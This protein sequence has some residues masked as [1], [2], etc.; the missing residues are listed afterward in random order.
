MSKFSVKKPLTIFVAVVM[1][2]VLGVVSYTK[3]TPDLLPSIDMPYVVVVTPYPGASPQKVERAVTKPLEQSLATLDNIKNVQSMSGENFSMVFME[4]TNDVNM[5]TV[6]VDIL[7]YIDLI[8]PNWDEKV[9]SPYILKM[10]PS[11]VPVLVAAVSYE[12]KDAEEI[13]R[14]L[15]DTLLDELDGVTGIAKVNTSGLIETD[16]TISISQEKI[17][18][19]NNKLLGTVNGKLSD[20]QK[21]LL[22]GQKKLDEAKAQ[23]KEQEDKLN[24]AK[25]STYDQLAE[26]KA[27]LNAGIAQV[28]ALQT[29]IQILEGDKMALE[30]QIQMANAGMLPGVNVTNLQ[31]QLATV[32]S[33]LDGLKAACGDAQA[34]LEELKKAYA[35]AEKGSYEA[36][37]QFGTLSDQMK[38]GQKQLADSQKTLNDG[39]KQMRDSSK[40]ALEQ[41]N[42]SGFITMD[43]ISGILK[44][45]NFDM[46]A[47]YV[48]AGD[49][50]VLVSVGDELTSKKEIADLV[51]FNIDGLGDVRVKDVATVTLVN[52]ADQ[53]YGNING[54]NGVLLTFSKQSNFATTISTNNLE[55]KFRALEEKYDG[56]S[57]TTL[58]S[59]GQYIYIIVESILSSL[60]WGALFA[61]IILLLF[62]RNV[63]PTFIT[64]CSIPISL[65]FAI[66]LMYFSGVTINMMSLSGLAVSVGMLVDNSVVVIENIYR[67][68]RNGVPVAKAAVAGAKQVSMAITA[69]TLTTLCVFLPIVFTEGITRSLFQD[70]ALTI[71]FALFASLL[72]ALTLVPAMSS[73]LLSKP[74]KEEGH[75]FDKLIEKY[76]KAIAWGLD[77][78][79]TI[80]GTTLIA[81]VVSLGISVGKGFIFIPEMSMPMMSGQVVTDE[82]ATLEETVEV[83]N[84]VVDKI[85]EVEGV[86]SCGAMLASQNAL[87]LDMG[88]GTT[89]QVSL[90][91]LLED[92]TKRSNKEIADEINEKCKGV[93]ATVE[94]MTSSSVTEYTSALGGSGVSL[95]L[96]GD[97]ERDL[98]KAAK[99]VGEAIEKLEGVKKV[100]NGIEELDR[101]FHFT[102]DKKKAAQNGLTVAQIY[103]EIANKLNTETEATS[104]TWEAEDYSINVEKSDK[105][106]VT[107]DDILNM[108][109]EANKSDG[110]VAKVKVK[111]VATLDDTTALSSINRYNQRTYLSVKGELK[112]GY[113]VTLVTEKATEAV[114][115]LELP[116]GITVEFDGENETIMDAMWQLLQMLLLGILFVYGVMVTQFQS[117]KSPFII[118]FTIPLAITGGLL[119]LIISGKEI[120]AVAM[121]GF[122]ML[123]GIIVNNGIVLVDYINQL[124][125]SGMTKREA[126]IQGGVTRIRPILMTTL[127]TVFGLIIMAIGKTAGTDMMQPVAI[128]CIGGLLYA[129][130]LTLFVVPCIYDLMN[131]EEYKH[132][133]EEDLDITGII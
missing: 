78:K 74:I 6:S 47:G 121:V 24:D 92:D 111:D 58:M 102:V 95:K 71:C 10:N 86:D 123:V 85:M 13:S 34:Q 80:L 105:G 33:Q 16:I 56:L 91:L 21:E 127:T 27:Q 35:S 29:Q 119:G 40:S 45:Q 122:I 120:S 103:S 90:Y 30:Q 2:I 39:K 67:L 96:Y 68:R 57:F 83:A 26:A 63:R 131:K 104:I 59:Q 14:F 17:D 94:I 1:V 118:I 43:T 18:R 88:G 15:N 28:S 25:N 53:V 101:E 106:D 49:D 22:D 20:A 41:A 70:M 82:E 108:T 107:V 93:D 32:T 19:L 9:G 23:L 72:I 48:T 69:S 52:N 77:H 64:L 79:K 44:A 31:M 62:L 51:M 100:D 61:I 65:T 114:E 89:N 7:S 60:L 38:E 132:V 81:L 84:Q 8:K 97:N 133:S 66:V 116:K 117:L 75:S 115:G 12:G 4:F 54:Q 11:M 113:N 125:E 87:G 99:M 112:D 110:S 3:M 129:T 128:V 109:I 124:R 42:I 50:K 126:I 5:D 98:Q 36:L 55:D 73:L 130:L 46:P 76:K 37:E